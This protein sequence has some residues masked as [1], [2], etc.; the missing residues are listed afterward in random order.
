MCANL[1]NVII[2]NLAIFYHKGFMCIPE[3]FLIFLRDV[4]NSCGKFQS[5][6]KDFLSYRRVKVD[7]I[8]LDEGIIFFILNAVKPLNYFFG[9]SPLVQIIKLFDL[10]D[11][12]VQ[13]NFG[14][15][16]YFSFGRVERSCEVSRGQITKA[17]VTM[18]QLKIR[19]YGLSH[20]S[21]CPLC[22]ENIAIN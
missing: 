19:Y 11:N 8:Q 16:A 10:D 17:I 7:Y 14:N 5:F 20:G 9:G 15:F 21:R 13:F 4:N 22:H 12:F 3:Y 1:F 18:I 2:N 6:Q